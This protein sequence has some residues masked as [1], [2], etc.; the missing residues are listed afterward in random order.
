M[1]WTRLAMFCRFCCDSHTQDHSGDHQLCIAAKN[2]T[3]YGP[4]Q[5][6]GDPNSSGIASS[7]TSCYQLCHLSAT[8]TD[9]SFGICLALHHQNSHQGSQLQQFECPLPFGFAMSSQAVRGVIHIYVYSHTY[10]QSYIRVICLAIK[11]KLLS[12]QDVY[13]CTWICILSMQC[14]RN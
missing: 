12:Q 1:P 2:W 13:A 7:C 8:V 6:S 9:S 5:M 14:V 3:K 11:G 10:V 4:S